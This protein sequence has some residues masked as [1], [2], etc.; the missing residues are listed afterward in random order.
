M[1][2][3]VYSKI[4]MPLVLDQD[5]RDAAKAYNSSRMSLVR[6]R[7]ILAGKFAACSERLR[8]PLY[9]LNSAAEFADIQLSVLSRIRTGEDDFVV[10]PDTPEPP[11]VP[12]VG[13][14]DTIGALLYT[15]EEIQAR[16]P[17]PI[18]RRA[19]PEPGENLPK[20][21]APMS[22]NIQIESRLFLNGVEAKTYT[23]QQLILMIESAE[24][25]VARLSKVATSSTKIAERI[26][27]LR[28]GANELAELLD[29]RK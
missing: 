8:L 1:K 29:S 9:L 27:A 16:C 7:E 6:V 26:E 14:N 15:L 3:E 20:Q 28:K 21:G 12:R 10:M 17:V 25:E 23:D 13:K 19:L 2:P 11:G 4:Y 18:L 24:A 22:N 5:L